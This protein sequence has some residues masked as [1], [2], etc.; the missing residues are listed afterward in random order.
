M[1]RRCAAPCLASAVRS[2]FPPGAKRLAGAAPVAPGSRH[3]GNLY[4]SLLVSLP[5]PAPK[6]YQLSLVAGVIVH[7]ALCALLPP[8]GAKRHCDLKWPND[9]LI[10]GAKAGGIL[11]E[12]TVTRERDGSPATSDESGRHAAGCDH[13]HRHQ[14]RARIP[15]ASTAR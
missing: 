7:E 14:H 13:R 15:R 8:H 12:S 11:I 10:D 5:A 4:A 6:A 2:G 9:I 1:R 3:D